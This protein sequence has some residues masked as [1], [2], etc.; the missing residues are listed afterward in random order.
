MVD[1]VASFCHFQFRRQGYLAVWKHFRKQSRKIVDTTV[2]YMKNNWLHYKYYISALL[3]SEDDKFSSRISFCFVQILMYQCWIVFVTELNCN[4]IRVWYLVQ[5][6]KF[7][8]Y[9]AISE[10]PWDPLKHWNIAKKHCK[11]YTYHLVIPRNLSLSSH[12]GLQYVFLDI[13]V[14]YLM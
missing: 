14:C 2:A 7:F 10:V 3:I 13:Y 4:F 6:F 1:D 12:S 9:L 11:I 5:P 8:M